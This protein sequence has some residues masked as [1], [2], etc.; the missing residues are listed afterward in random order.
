[1]GINLDM[2][3]FGEEEMNFKCDEV[4]LNLEVGL[5]VIEGVNCVRVLVLNE[6]SDGFL[7]ENFF[8]FQ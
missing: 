8:G 6:F 5:E 4:Y 2:S 7:Q 1:M 3:Q